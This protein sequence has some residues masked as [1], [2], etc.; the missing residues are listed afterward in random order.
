VGRG[1]SHVGAAGSFVG[2]TGTSVRAHRRARGP[3]R[4]RQA[5]RRDEGEPIETNHQGE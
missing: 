4:M 3:P 5:R 2:A 1:G